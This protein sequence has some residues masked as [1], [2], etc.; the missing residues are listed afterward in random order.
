MTTIVQEIRTIQPRTIKDDC[1][2]RADLAKIGF[3][4]LFAERPGSGDYCLL[5]PNGQR[6]GREIPLTGVPIDRNSLRPPPPDG[7]ALWELKNRYW[8]D[9]VAYSGDSFKRLR[10]ALLGGAPFKWPLD[11][12]PAPPEAAQ[13]NSH[14]AGLA[15]LRFLKN[16]HANASAVL[17]Q[18]Q[19][20]IKDHSPQ[21][22]EA[23]AK[24]DKQR[25]DVEEARALAYKRQEEIKAI[26]LS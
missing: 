17:A 2:I 12:L 16:F 11:R 15:A 20:L 6:A 7:P 3:P 21:Q 10:S 23:K 22:V 13:G 25:R 26:S 8:S 1:E 4:I 9:M 18:V 19:Q 5:Y 14:E 24:A